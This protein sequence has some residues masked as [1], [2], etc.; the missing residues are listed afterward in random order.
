MDTRLVSSLFSLIVATSNAGVC[1]RA[2][3]EN[4]ETTA[5]TEIAKIA[6]KTGFGFLCDLCDLCV[7]TLLMLSTY[8][9]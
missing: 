6:E 2:I 8:G 1:V 4:A 9:R 7:E 5:N 3:V